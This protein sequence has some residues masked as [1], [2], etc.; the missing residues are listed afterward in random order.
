MR[1]RGRL[2]VRSS[3]GSGIKGSGLRVGGGFGLSGYSCFVDVLRCDGCS[4]SE[5]GGSGGKIVG[6]ELKWVGGVLDCVCKEWYGG[7]VVES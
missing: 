4:V 2:S 7:Y 5:M 6:R 3:V 1:C